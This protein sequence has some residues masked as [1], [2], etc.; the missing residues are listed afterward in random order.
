MSILK[1]DLDVRLDT[2]KEILEEYIKVCKFILENFYKLHI[3]K[4]IVRNSNKRGHH[5][6]I[7]LHEYLDDAT[8]NKLQ[9]MLG[10]DRTRWKINQI[11]IE[12]GIKRWNI[13]FT[14]VLWE[15]AKTEPCKSCK[16]I[17]LLQSDM[18]TEETKN[19]KLIEYT[20]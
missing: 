10:D 11:R 14:D 15:K 18:H 2:H 19:K 9:F 17:E 20:C 4:I 13:L 6:W 16:L 7:H 3:R 8:I 5:I 12:R 1:I